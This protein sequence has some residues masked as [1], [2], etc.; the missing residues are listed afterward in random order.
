MRIPRSRSGRINVFQRVKAGKSVISVMRSENVVC[1]V[2][3]SCGDKSA[4][5]IVVIYLRN[6][7]C[8]VFYSRNG[9]E[10]VMCVIYCRLFVIIIP[11]GY[12][13]VKIIVNIIYTCSVAVCAR[14][15]FSVVRGEG[16][17]AHL[18]IFFSYIILFLILLISNPSVLFFSLF[19]LLSNPLF[20]SSFI[21]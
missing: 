4:Y 21:F 13:S 8:G 6:S 3:R 7:A 17:I 10:A 16:S 9:A 20:L 18:A 15:Q 5:G 14:C 2:F 1:T 11:Q 12:N 19:I